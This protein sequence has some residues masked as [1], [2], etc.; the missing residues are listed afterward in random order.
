MSTIPAIANNHASYIASVKQ[1][2]THDH[3]PFLSFTTDIFPSTQRQP[4]F[5]HPVSQVD[6]DSI[7]FSWPSGLSSTLPTPHGPLAPVR[8]PL[9]LPPCCASFVAVVAE[10]SALLPFPRCSKPSSLFPFWIN[11]TSPSSWLVL[12]FLSGNKHQTTTSPCLRRSSC[13]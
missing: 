11:P 10:S 4:T 2:T 7:S 6:V 8:K 3:A 5:H 9:L 1:K 13:Q 12:I